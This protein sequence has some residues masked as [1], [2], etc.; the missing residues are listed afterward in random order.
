MKITAQ[1]SLVLSP[2]K[3]MNE[4]RSRKRNHLLD[5]DLMLGLWYPL[6]TRV[7]YPRTGGYG[8]TR[9]TRYGGALPVRGYARVRVYRVLM[10]EPAR[11]PAPRSQDASRHLSQN[12]KRLNLIIEST[13]TGNRQRC[14]SNFCTAA[15]A[16]FR[17]QIVNQPKGRPAQHVSC[18]A[19]RMHELRIVGLI[20]HS[21]RDST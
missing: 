13:A 15:I 3:S 1:I 16:H 2:A 19:I 14:E 8:G 10:R 20:Q 4:I 7:S 6:P 18:N 5:L 21:C 11:A 9:V 12:Q 17:K